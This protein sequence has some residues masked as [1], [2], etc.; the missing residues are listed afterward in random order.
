[1][2]LAAEH[3]AKALD[4]LPDR[5]TRGR[6]DADI[7]RGDIEP[8]DERFRAHDHPR[9]AIAK[10]LNAFG[11]EAAGKLAVLKDGR[12]ARLEG[13]EEEPV[14]LLHALVKDDCPA[15][16]IGKRFLQDP[17]HGHGASPGP[18]EEPLPFAREADEADC[19]E[20]AFA[21]HRLAPRD[22]GLL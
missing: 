15:L 8:L 14:Y 1:M 13:T 21:A 19:V 2:R 10:G 5:P 9:R 7:S 6:D 12:I 17:E 11:A 22:E 18:V 20:V 16:G 4:P 3:A